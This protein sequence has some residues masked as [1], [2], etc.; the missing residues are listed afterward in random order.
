M[1]WQEDEE[2]G[3]YN[4]VLLVADQGSQVTYVE[5]YISNNDEKASVA[6]IISEVIA[7][8]QAK[9]SYGAVDNFAKGTTTY[10]NRRGVAYRDATIEWALGQMNDGNTISENHTDLMGDNSFSEA[11]AVTVGRGDQKQDFVANIT[12]YG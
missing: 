2:A 1:F 8:D 5:N 9:V 6:N 12:H 10:V 7:H 11:K 3:L 4:H